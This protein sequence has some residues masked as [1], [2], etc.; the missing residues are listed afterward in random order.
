MSHSERFCVNSGSTTRRRIDVHLD[1][2]DQ[3]GWGSAWLSAG[4][5]SF[6]HQDFLGHMVVM[7]VQI[8]LL[9]NLKKIKSYK[10]YMQLPSRRVK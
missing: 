9:S 10:S 3:S 7:P 1:G 6:N 4:G 5:I 8:G 2:S